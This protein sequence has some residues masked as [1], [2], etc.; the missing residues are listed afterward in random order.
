MK[1]FLS[2]TLT[3]MLTLS[4]LLF[5]GCKEKGLN[6][7]FYDYETGY[8]IATVNT[9]ENEATALCVIEAFNSDGDDVGY[10][11]PETETFSVLF[12]DPKDSTYDI[13]YKVAIHD[14]KVYAKLDTEQMDEEYGK[15]MLET[16]GFNDEVYG[17]MNI[18]EE[19]FRGFLYI[20]E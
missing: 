9:V 11:V 15:T 2:F 12:E 1:R 17:E 20:G 13:W 5:S 8:D 14:G 3:V 18:T 19:E 16:G 4:L 7:I 6:I 10:N